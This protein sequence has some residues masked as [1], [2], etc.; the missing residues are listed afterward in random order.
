MFK[1]VPKQYGIILYLDH[2]SS[3]GY[4]TECHSRNKEVK[5]RIHLLPGRLSLCLKII[6]HEYY[7]SY[8]LL[9]YCIIILNK[10]GISWHKC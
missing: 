1:T 9:N 10:Y 4:P 3:R 8:F 6:L 7:T 2:I 5:T